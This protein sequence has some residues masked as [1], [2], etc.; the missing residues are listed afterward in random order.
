MRK[1]KKKFFRNLSL[2]RIIPNLATLSALLIGMTQVRFALKEQWEFAVVAV[3]IAA[4]FDATDGRLARILNS[5]SRF[6]AELDSLSDFAVFG[7]CPAFVMYL[8]SLNTLNR[9][10][11]IISVFFAVCMALRLARFNTHDIENIK[12]PL[13]GKFFTGVPAPAGA[14]L[15]LFPVILF[16]AFNLSIFQNEYLCAINVVIAGLLC[17]SKIPTLS[18]KKFHIK[19]SN[20]TIFL[21]AA[22]VTI[23]VI[24]TYTWRAFCVIILSYIISIFI[25]SK[26]AKSILKNINDSS[27]SNK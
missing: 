20:Y 10:G 2:A 12:T 18:I 11:W 3:V 23:G 27:N 16:N 25:C 7:L 4:F 26:K 13:S 8:Y 22:I 21:L 14:I 17:V 6:G 5:C 1:N 24:F 15:A 9:L 19:R